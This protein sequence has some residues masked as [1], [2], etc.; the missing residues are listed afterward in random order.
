[1]FTFDCS[2]LKWL[3]C[4][5]AVRLNICQHINDIRKPSMTVAL[6]HFPNYVEVNRC[7]WGMDGNGQLRWSSNNAR[8]LVHTLQPSQMECRCVEII[9]IFS[10]PRRRHLQPHARHGKQWSVMSQIPVCNLTQMLVSKRQKWN[11]TQKFCRR[12]NP[13]E[14]VYGF[15]VSLRRNFSNP[16]FLHFLNL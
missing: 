1:M 7:E 6:N 16:L 15:K 9:S 10:Q 14:E 3:F 8:P 12:N 13:P 2:R 11:H 4:Q 5:S